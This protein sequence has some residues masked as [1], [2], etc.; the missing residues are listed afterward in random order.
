MYV[1]ETTVKQLNALLTATFQMNS[2]CDN[3]AYNAGALK[4]VNFEDIFH[5]KFAHA[6]P[7]LAD[8]ISDLMIQAQCLPV[9]GAL[10]ANDKTYRPENYAEMFV[11]LLNDVKNYRTLIIRT[12]ETAEYNDDY[13]IKIKLEEY[14]LYFLKLLN[15]A[16]IWFVKAQQY[17]SIS[18]FDHDFES[19]T[20]L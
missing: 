17:K 13:E 4:A 11:D 18:E 14:L 1:K 10:S 15:Q 7:A 9:R 3:I 19:F 5:H 16:E 2:I 20:K 12:I 8:Q 6:F